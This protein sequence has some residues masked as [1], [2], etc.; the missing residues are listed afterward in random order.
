MNPEEEKE[1]AI[2]RQQKH[3]EFKQELRQNEKF[4]KFLQR[5]YPSYRENFIDDYASEKVRWVEWGPKHIEWMEQE[6]LQW[7]ND[8]NRRLKEIQQKKLFDQQCLWRAEKTEL[9]QIRVTRDF[10]YW[11]DNIMNCPF[12]EPVTKEEVELYSQYLQSENIQLEVGFLERWQDYV[13]IK[14]AYNSD[15]ASRNFPDWYDFHNSRTGL[16]AYLILPDVRGEKERFYL[17][18]FR[19]EKEVERKKAQQTSPTSAR[20]RIETLPSLDRYRKNYLTW[21]VKT[22]EDKKTQQHFER[23]GGENAYDHFDEFLDR[24]LELLGRADSIVP[25][26]GW[27]DW[28]EAIHKA[29]HQYRCEKIA[30]A[31]PHVY[32]QYQMSVDLELAF[33]EPEPIFKLDDW[34]HNA[35]LRGREL[36]G[37][38]KDFN[39]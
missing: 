35:I 19:K 37:E 2:W 29:A 30:E 25:I 16:S 9:P 3:L 23:C 34:Y 17:S 18:L 33:E 11:E 6:D 7:L 8:A 12:I 1:K 10:G 4:M 15:N 28:R 20:E 27:F 14:Q 26:K 22:F 32:E 38:P 5:G 24:D 31:L 39:F 36:N 13:E 21:F